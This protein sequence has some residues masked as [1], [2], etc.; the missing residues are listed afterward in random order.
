MEFEPS[1]VVWRGRGGSAA[2]D[3]SAANGKEGS[4]LVLVTT[5]EEVLEYCTQSRSCVHH[6]TFRAGSS[7]ALRV[8]AVRNPNSHVLFGVR[9]AKKANQPETLVAWRNSDL[10]VAKWKSAPLAEKSAVVGLYVHP[11]LT[12]E[13]V[14]VFENGRFAVY[15][16]DLAKLLDTSDALAN[17]FDDAAVDGHVVYAALASDHRNPVRGALFLSLLLK[18]K[19]STGA[20]YELVIYQV[21]TKKDR[22]DARVAATLVM[23]HPVALQDTGAKAG[24]EVASAAFHADTFAFSFVWSTGEWQMVAFTHDAV[25]NALEWT[26]SQTV[27]SFSA[28]YTVPASLTPTNKKR[29]LAHGAAS[30]AGLK[31]CGVGHFSYLVVSSASNPRVLAGWDSKFGV[32]VAAAEIDFSSPETESGDAKPAA[33]A[34]AGALLKLVSSPNG[35]VVVAAYEH[36]VFF[37]NVKNKHSTLASVLGAAASSAVKSAAP[38]LPNSAINWADVA[39]KPVAPGDW[40]AQLC[41]ESAA[42]QQFISDLSDASVTATAAQFSKKFDEALKALRARGGELSYRFLVAVTKRCVESA[43]LGLWA[44]LR[45]MIA[46][47]R[48]SA[49][50]VPALLPTLMKHRQYALLELA[51]LHLTDIDERSIVRLLKFFIRKSEDKALVAYASGA[52]SPTAAGSKRKQSGAASA[53]A[54]SASERFLVALLAL[55]TNSVFLHHAIRE[56]QLDDALLLLAV[57]K[58]F[59]CALT[60]SALESEAD[61]SA[62]AGARKKKSPKKANGVAPSPSPSPSSPSLYALVTASARETLYFTTLPTALQFAVWIC[63]LIDGH[64]AQLV[65]AASKNA[66]VASGLQRLDALVQK[67][68]ESCEQFEGVQS[69]L[70]NFLSGVKLPQAHGIPD[71]SI[72]E[73]LI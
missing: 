19:V 63:A 26:S 15:D 1:V 67:Q 14:V 6:W 66:T 73:L 7:V 54:V 45:A 4:K 50:A 46:S 68:L 60:I 52:G 42:E 65:L 31:I 59:L 64:F 56:L 20:P 32:Q 40:T 57:C 34:S 12:E 69:V 55:P 29:K 8:G 72:E 49:R 51:I 22:K 27:T 3:V 62:A 71:Y 5:R 28:D 35:E 24:A 16:E 38:G 21:F 10:E 36:A 23:R 17:G 44:P 2:L 9:G 11:Q 13:V 70:S 37:V 43:V 18:S 41:S 25:G 48:I 53:A 58:K 30:A 61:A 47:K 33:A 39:A